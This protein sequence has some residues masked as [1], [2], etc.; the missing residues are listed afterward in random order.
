M[1]GITRGER[2]RRKM[3]SWKPKVRRVRS[4]RGAFETRAVGFQSTLLG[5]APPALHIAIDCREGGGEG[6]AGQGHRGWHHC[7]PPARRPT[8]LTSRP[9]VKPFIHSRINL[10]SFM[11]ALGNK[12]R[13]FARSLAEQG[14]VRIDGLSL[15]P[16]AEKGYWTLKCFLIVDIV[17]GWFFN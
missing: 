13:V 17:C 16:V 7:G 6:A 3:Q 11:L 4:Q 5:A 14:C 12:L 15:E 1:V 10:A 9:R 8:N 2:K